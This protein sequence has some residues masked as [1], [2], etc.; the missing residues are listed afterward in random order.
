MRKLIATSLLLLFLATPL[1]AQ[2]ADKVMPSQE[3]LITLQQNGKVLQLQN[4]STGDKLEVLNIVGVKVLE[5]KLESSNQS[6]SLDLPKGYY[7]VKI[8]AT[9]R[10]I[11]IK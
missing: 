2:K 10:K 11:S 3:T 4:F 6:F 9:V 7:I 1:I 8:G 5:K